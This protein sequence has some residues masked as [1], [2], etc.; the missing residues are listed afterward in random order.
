PSEFT[1]IGTDRVRRK[2]SAVKSTGTAR[3]TQDVHLPDML[4]AMVAHSPRFGGKGK[5]FDASA[6]RQVPGVVDVFQIPTGVA[7]VAQNT[8]AA[9]QGRDAVQVQW[10][11]AKAERISSDTLMKHY[12]AI[13]AG[14]SAPNVKWQSFATRGAPFAE[15]PDDV[16]ATYDFP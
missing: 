6:A 7:V 8:W 4:T 2:D 12:R 9:R 10:D 16:V 1:L 15:R 3:Y 5:S 11:D 13:A 14:E